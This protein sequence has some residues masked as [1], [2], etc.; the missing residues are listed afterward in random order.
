MKRTKV[1]EVKGWAVYHLDNGEVCRTIDR[2]TVLL[3]YAIFRT[4][5]AAIEYGK[6]VE[7]ARGLDIIP[8]RIVPI[9]SKK[10]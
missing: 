4:K 10:R 1:K 5:G 3:S 2:N 6:W 9:T 8:V 7:S